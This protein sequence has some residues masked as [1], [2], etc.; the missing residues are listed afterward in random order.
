M[1]KAIYMVGL[2]VILC[3]L[4]FPVCTPGAKPPAEVKTLKLGCIMPFTGAAAQWGLLMRPEMEVYAELVN[5]D[6]GMKVGNDTYKVEV[7]FLDDGFMPA[8][9]AAAARKLMYDQGV[10]AMVG[11]FSQGEAAV[12]PITNAE[13]VIFICRT[14][15]GV[16]YDP[17][18]DKYVV[19][20]T[21]SSEN[22]AYQVVAAMK[23]YPDFKIIG[24]TGPEAARLAAESAFE[25]MD[26]A[27]EERYGMKGYRFYYPEG[28]TNFTP[29]IAKMAEKGVQ[30]VSHGGSMLE[31]ALIAKQRWAA[32]YKW[33]IQQT[34]TLVNP[35][36]FISIAGFDAAQGI[37]SDRPV[38]WE[39]KKVKVAPDYL[40]MAKRIKARFEEKYKEPMVY[41]GCYGWG[42]H[43]MALYFE[44]VKRAG[45]LDADKVMENIRGGTFE[46]FLGKYTMGGA[47]TYGSPVVC[48]YPCPVGIIK[49]NEEVYLGEHTLLDADMWNKP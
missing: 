23:A 48:G 33:P 36:M 38:P 34:G 9:G 43:H 35:A 3:T 2:V 15:S 1:R 20:G 13:K 32:G 10:V 22:V 26:K 21:P 49:G 5:E 17:E 12:A 6:G 41:M 30:M 29:Y 7:Y 16:V 4:L 11:Y 18:K 44:A 8:P 42:V 46:T 31:V 39:L 37:V 45:T 27:I 40:D 19:F 14:G 24:W 47:E 25:Q 28:T